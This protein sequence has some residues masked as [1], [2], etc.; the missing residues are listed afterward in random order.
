[1]LSKYLTPIQGVFRL[2]QVNIDT[3]QLYIQVNIDVA[4]W[5][6]TGGLTIS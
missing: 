5:I 2:M 4:Y 3:N 1:M 6:M